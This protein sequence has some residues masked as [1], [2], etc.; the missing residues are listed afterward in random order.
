[1]KKECCINLRLTDI[2][3]REVDRR[4]TYAG[5]P[6]S[7]YIRSLVQRDISTNIDEVIRRLARMIMFSSVAIR[8]LYTKIDHEDE[9]SV[10]KQEADRLIAKLGV[11]NT[12]D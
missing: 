9:L 12:D 3:Y 8:H 6:T 10:V 11:I 5:L 7:E 1:M 4:A 2:Q